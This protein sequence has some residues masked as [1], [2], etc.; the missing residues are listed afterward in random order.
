VECLELLLLLEQLHSN[1]L[2]F[3]GMYD[4]VTTD[5][6][7]VV[8]VDHPVWHNVLVVEFTG[9]SGRLRKLEFKL[10]VGLQGVNELHNTHQV[11]FIAQL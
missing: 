10:W 6:H 3:A 2:T 5:G 4:P 7:V 8:L 9:E 1:T 11:C